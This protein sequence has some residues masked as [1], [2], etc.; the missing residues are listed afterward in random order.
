MPAAST[1]L[2]SSAVYVSVPPAAK[3]RDRIVGW[4]TRVLIEFG[5]SVGIGQWARERCVSVET[6]E[7]I[8]RRDPQLAFTGFG[9]ARDRYLKLEN[10]SIWDVDLDNGEE[11][12]IT[13]SKS[14]STSA[15]SSHDTGIASSPWISADVL[16]GAG[17]RSWLLNAFTLIHDPTAV[18]RSRRVTSFT[19]L[20]LFSSEI[21]NRLCSPYARKF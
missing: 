1:Q 10:R 5:V 3:V 8:L 12:K 15:A 21:G 14:C 13:G 2:F 16:A 11:G 17:A 6:W 20:M 9:C 4:R 18:L 19:A 7:S